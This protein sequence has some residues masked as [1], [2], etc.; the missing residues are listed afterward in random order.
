MTVLERG[1][2]QLAIGGQLVVMLFI[3]A[4]MP[5]SASGQ[6]EA[7]PTTGPATPAPTKTTEI[8][9]VGSP[10][11]EIKVI[12]PDGK[13]LK[14]I[15]IIIGTGERPSAQAPTIWMVGPDG[16]QIQLRPSDPKV[17]QTDLLGAL[18]F[19]AIKPAP[20]AIKPT[21][22]VPGAIALSRV[23]YKLPKEKAEALAAFLKANVHPS[24]LEFKTDGVG[25]TV[26]TTPEAQ[27]TIHG[28]VTLMQA[29]ND[30]MD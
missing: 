16:K 30:K 23:T 14:N 5:A 13:E 3:A 29:K 9:G 4:V 22:N 28:I 8:R 24:V 19:L 21:P 26:T 1:L 20:L 10:Q 25:L 12:G 15:K 17:T 6:G 11:S 27:S 2:R 7:N 18:K